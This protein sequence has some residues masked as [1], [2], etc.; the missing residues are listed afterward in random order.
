MEDFDMADLLPIVDEI[1]LG[2]FTSMRMRNIGGMG[3][4][5][6]TWLDVDAYS[7]MSCDNLTKWE[8][9]Q[10]I[11]MSVLYCTWLKKGEEIGCPSPWESD[12]QQTIDL[13]RKL[14]ND[15]MKSMRA[16][17]KKAP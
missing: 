7:R 8:S 13:N 1:V 12:E 9:E 5:P 17:R 16:A 10:V 3:A 11:T 4:S 14:V 15:R 6:L 2:A